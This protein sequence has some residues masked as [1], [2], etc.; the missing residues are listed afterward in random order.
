[1]IF[2]VCGEKIPARSWREMTG[3]SGAMGGGTGSKMGIVSFVSS[4]SVASSDNMSLKDVEF[5]A[6]IW[7]NLCSQ[8]L[9]LGE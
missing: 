3:S 8:H 2:N 5:D 4:V 1:L 9:W 6:S 7:D